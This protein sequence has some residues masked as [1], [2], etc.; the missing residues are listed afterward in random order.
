M[1]HLLM[2]VALLGAACGLPAQ[3]LSSAGDWSFCKDA[4]RRARRPSAT[5]GLVLRSVNS[6]PYVGGLVGQTAEAM[7]GRLC[8]HT[9]I[10]PSPI[11]AA[12]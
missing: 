6:W 12:V 11:S 8:P 2:A 10:I 5:L 1:R 7:P 9:P 3:A 4:Y